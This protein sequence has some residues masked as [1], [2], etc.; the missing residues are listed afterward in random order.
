LPK[1]PT[2]PARR[3]VC[4]SSRGYFEDTL[5]SGRGRDGWI[6]FKEEKSGPFPQD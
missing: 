6:I 5:L 2:T 4:A 1:A 3:K